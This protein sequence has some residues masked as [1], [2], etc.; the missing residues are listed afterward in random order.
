[1]L[2]NIISHSKQNDTTT[3]LKFG[4]RTLAK[5]VVLDIEDITD[6]DIINDTTLHQTLARVKTP[7]L[8]GASYRWKSVFHVYTSNRPCPNL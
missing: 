7:F 6:G 5:N 4:E 3:T 1:M 2:A 8:L